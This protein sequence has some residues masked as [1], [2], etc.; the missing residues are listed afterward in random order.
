M[1]TTAFQN[2]LPDDG[3]KSESPIDDVEMLW[4][5]LL[6]DNKYELLFVI[7]FCRCISANYKVRM[8]ALIKR[9]KI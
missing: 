4:L 5:R 3:H 7:F 1:M 9:N 6:V 2:N 8:L